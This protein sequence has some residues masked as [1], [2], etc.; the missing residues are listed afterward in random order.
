MKMS[1][2]STNV[3]FIYFFNVFFVGFFFCWQS[4][5]LKLNPRLSFPWFSPAFDFK[6]S[7]EGGGGPSSLKQ[8]QKGHR[9]QEQQATEAGLERGRAS[10]SVVVRRVGIQSWSATRTL[11]TYTHTASRAADVITWKREQ[12]G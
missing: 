2:H 11:A 10:D 1:S 7:T 8:Q 9:E 4:Y 3:S 6:L 12:Y 5:F